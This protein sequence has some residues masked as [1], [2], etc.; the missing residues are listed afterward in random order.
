MPAIV[1][2]TWVCE[3]QWLL[4]PGSFAFVETEGLSYNLWG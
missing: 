1:D 2:P 4:K 3:G